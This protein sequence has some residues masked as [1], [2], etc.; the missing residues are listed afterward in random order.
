MGKKTIMK[1][2]EYYVYVWLDPRKQGKYK[3][4]D[5][6]FLHEPLYVGKGT[7]R[8]L[9][10]SKH[11]HNP[12]LQNKLQK[13]KPIILILFNKL[14]EKKSIELEK[15]LISLIGR[16]V[17]GGPLCNLTDGG[18]GISGH[19]H[20][21]ETKLKMSE[22]TKNRKPVSEETKKKISETK[23]GRKL[24]KEHIEK[25]RKS[26]TGKKRTEEYC[27]KMSILRK[28]EKRSE[29][30]KKKMSIAKLGKKQSEETIQ[31]RIAFLKGK[32]MTDQ[33]KLKISKGIKQHWLYRKENKIFPYNTP[34]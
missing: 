32:K 6:K 9:G 20:S 24:T 2:R 18:D 16:R 26:N 14:T 31:K 4:G 11:E 17:N 21:K 23:T 22:A 27:K 28:G 5:H 8:R 30:A 25:I 34:N 1:R 3:Y 15:L 13:M 29:E 7:G 19:I 10:T 33:F 12:I